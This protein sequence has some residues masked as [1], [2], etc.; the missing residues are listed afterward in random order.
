VPGRRPLPVAQRVLLVDPVA[1][2]GLI[3]G[4]VRRGA[5]VARG[6]CLTLGGDG[7]AL[8]ERRADG[9]EVLVVRRRWHV[10]Q[11]RVVRCG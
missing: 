1:H 9:E 6:E 3:G 7:E 2:Q 4:V 5:Q 10:H 8:G 11:K